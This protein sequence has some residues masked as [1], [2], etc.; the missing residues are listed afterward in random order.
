[1]FFDYDATNVRELVFLANGTAPIGEAN[2][3]LSDEAKEN[4]FSSMSF[5]R[6]SRY[7]PI[8]EIADQADEDVEFE[9]GDAVSLNVSDDYLDLSDLWPDDTFSLNEADDAEELRLEELAQAYKPKTRHVVGK[10]PSVIS[11][12]DIT[13]S[14]RGRGRCH[15]GRHASWK[16]ARKLPY[17]FMRVPARF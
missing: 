1:M 7:T 8:D 15:Y 11:D 17:Q 2:D 6:K 13:S 5:P 9:Y 4:L 12:L 3:I 16:S 10:N 14:E